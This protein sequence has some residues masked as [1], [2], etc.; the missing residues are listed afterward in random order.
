MLT[1]QFK[2]I[3]IKIEISCPKN[4][5][6]IKRI[7]FITTVSKQFAYS[8]FRTCDVTTSK[9]KITTPTSISNS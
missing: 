8:A 5:W 1:P 3:I 7:T 2:K 9:Y 4:I 6:K